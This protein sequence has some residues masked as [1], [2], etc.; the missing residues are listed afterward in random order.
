MLFSGIACLEGVPGSGVFVF[1]KESGLT[2]S[3]YETFEKRLV[4]LKGFKFTIFSS[5]SHV[6][7]LMAGS[8]NGNKRR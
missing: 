8:M 4:L 2:I 1:L 5:D 6:S 7:P 3:Q